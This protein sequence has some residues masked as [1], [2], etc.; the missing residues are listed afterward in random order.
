MD[1][2]VAVKTDFIDL[3]ARLI[4]G[5]DDSDPIERTGKDLTCS[6]PFL[7]QW[8]DDCDFP[9]LMETLALPDNVFGQEFPGI[10]LSQAERAAFANTL[11]IHCRECAPCHVK[12]QEDLE[13][14]AR[15]E[16]A[17]AEN[18]QTIAALLRKP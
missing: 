5:S 6:Q 8:I 14:K 2:R 3:L 7:G 17:L 18:K 15:V 1:T 16:K 4:A 12:Q 10:R 13:L 11:E 9:F